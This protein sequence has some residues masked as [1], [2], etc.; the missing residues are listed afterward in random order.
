M[1]DERHVWEGGEQEDVSYLKEMVLHQNNVVALASA[2]LVGAV[3]SFPLGLG[4]ALI[5]VLLFAAGE[6][7]AAMF[8]PSSPVFRDRID[9]R[10]RAQRR[11]AAREHL[12]TE[13]SR[14][15]QDTG[16]N[17][18]AYHRMRERLE[19]LQELAR[20]RDTAL[21]DRDVEKLDD[22]TVDFLGMWLAAL[23][24]AERRMTVDVRG[25]EQR[26][27]SIEAQLGAGLPSAEARKLEAAQ[28]DLGR[29][30]ERHRGL[31]ARATA[32]DAAMLSMV[33]TFE[34]VYQRVMTNPQSSDA[35]AQ[36]N[37]AVERMRMQ[38][39]LD[40]A[41]DAELDDLL[42]RGRAKAARRQQ[43]G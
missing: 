5:P 33:D 22:A 25:L 41:V 26:M 2:V 16:G 12:V 3:L 18:N 23:V 34:E 11:E 19:S 43:A 38:E 28:A 36:L 9:R 6:S 42:R 13:I 8:L 37:E 35:G 32:L 24:M 39:E 1:A 15:F 31:R 7:I 20:S 14:R 21:S 27:R 17:W 30:L 40:V 29:V 4:P 10:K